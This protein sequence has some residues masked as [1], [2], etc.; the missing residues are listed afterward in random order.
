MRTID[1]PGNDMTLDEVI[2]RL[3]RHDAVD[4]IVTLGSTGRETLHPT[5]DF[6][7]LL[8]MSHMPIP[9]HVALARVDRRM[10]D[11]V[12]VTAVLL[13]QLAAAEDVWL[14]QDD[15]AGRLTRWLESGSIAFDRRGQL[16][17][18]QARI[19]SSP[20]IH[21]P[22]FKDRYA[23]W[24]KA[25][26]NVEQTRRY[27]ATPDPVYAFAAELRML[28]QLADLM[29]DY[30]RLR[31]LPWEGEKAAI[32]HWAARDPVYLDAFRA[33]LH[34]SELAGKLERY[35]HLASL[36][37]APV[38]GLWPA[39]ATAMMLS[40]ETEYEA[41]AVDASLAFWGELLGTSS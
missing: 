25:N 30:F 34:E 22:T 29:V 21:A 5:S 27:V 4:G 15:E 10:T 23:C 6:D 9:L 33:C 28:Y 2:A 8:V 12:F 7:M 14:V 1:S 3:A 41:N 19:R 39:G 16:R 32:R 18:V 17:K 31:G 26:Y 36:T 24:F 37:L 38:G 20:L 11:V 40:S 13:D 35:E